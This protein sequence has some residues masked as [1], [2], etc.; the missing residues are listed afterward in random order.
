[1]DKKKNETSNALDNYK[2]L[3]IIGKG[4]Y[5]RVHRAIDL[6][7]SKVL[8]VKIIDMEEIDSELEDILKEIRYLSDCC[9]DYITEYYTS[10]ACTHKLW[11]IM[12]YVGG[13][14]VL[15]I[16]QMGSIDEIYC[17]IILRD[18]LKG[19]NYLHQNNKIHRDIKCG[20]ILISEYAQVKLADFGVAGELTKFTN[21]R[22]TFVGTPYW[23]APEV[24]KEEEYGTA[25]DIWSFGISAIEMVDTKPP[26]FEEHPMK[27]LM[28]IPQ[29][30]PPVP[31]NMNISK[32]FR[33][34]IA[35]CLNKDPDT[36]AD[37]Q[38]LLKT[39]FIKKAKKNHYL[40]PLIQ[41][42]KVFFQNKKNSDLICEEEDE[43][44]ANDEQEEGAWLYETVRIADRELAR[45]MLKNA[46]IQTPVAKSEKEGVLTDGKSTF[47]MPTPD[48][49]LSSENITETGSHENISVSDQSRIILLSV[50]KQLRVKHSCCEKQLVELEKIFSTDQT[51]LFTH[52]LTSSIQ[53]FVP[54]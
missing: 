16:L 15:Q 1:M 4:S 28:T 48:I 22:R 52:A 18:V 32:I 44:N 53:K 20:N 37:A 19:L 10:Y 6:R 25:V 36:R 21:K 54:C 33:A 14:S 40:E 7:T 2:L 23:M 17:Q 13:G 3:E 39:Q 9:S 12:E 11:I 30:E 8:A 50:F 43:E 5:G 35:L 47:D 24:I 31:L 45:T 46:N 42:Y 34:F 51:Q 27:A 41:K 29:V 26:R 49:K 38:F